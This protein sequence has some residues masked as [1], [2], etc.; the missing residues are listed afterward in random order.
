MKEQSISPQADMRG[1]HYALTPFVRQQEWAM[2]VLQKQLAQLSKALFQAQEELQGMQAALQAQ[3]HQ[4]QQAMLQRANP[5]AY[6]QG[7]GFLVQLQQNIVLTHK[8][9]EA[10]RTQH[11]KTQAAC[12]AQHCK[13]DGLAEHRIQAENDYVN[14]LTRLAATEADRDWI[15]RRHLQSGSYAGISMQERA[16]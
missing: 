3:S 12:V 15:G 2:E 5:Q 7:L 6:Q 11:S 16:T 14:E 9:L 8:K 10:L 13:L 4:M 1:F